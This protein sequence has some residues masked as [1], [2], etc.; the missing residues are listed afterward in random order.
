MP[1]C[2][3]RVIVSS[4]TLT[5]SAAAHRNYRW[6]FSID[7]F[8][9]QGYRFDDVV[10]LI[11]SL[12]ASI[13]YDWFQR[14]AT[15]FA[16]KYHQPNTQSTIHFV[17]H[18]LYCLYVATGDDSICSRVCLIKHIVDDTPCS[19]LTVL[20]RCCRYQRRDW[21]TV[22]LPSGWYVIYNLY[23]IKQH[24][25]VVMS[26]LQCNWSNEIPPWSGSWYTP[27]VFIYLRL[28]SGTLRV[29]LFIT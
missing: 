5:T 24:V 26:V 11:K 25:V 19:T 13:I 27:I 22:I 9:S 7:A 28:S 23:W 12:A 17:Q 3:P 4:I 16:V 20:F 1:C 6:L 2:N 14:K 8:L 10:W 15:A 21:T 18:R 29:V